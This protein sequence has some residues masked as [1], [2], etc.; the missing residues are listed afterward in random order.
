MAVLTM[1]G[2]AANG[3]QANSQGKTK[4]P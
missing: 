3:Q 2:V 1:A 4:S